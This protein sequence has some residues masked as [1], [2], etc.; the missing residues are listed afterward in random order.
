MREVPRQ[1]LVR[2]GFIRL[3]EAVESLDRAYEER[4]FSLG[5]YLNREPVFVQLH[6][7]RVPPL[8]PTRGGHEESKRPILL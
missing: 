4:D 7:E 8:D 3:F 6:S 1:H 2:P 5:A